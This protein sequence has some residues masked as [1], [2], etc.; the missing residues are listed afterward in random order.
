M[1]EFP[2]PK[3]RSVFFDNKKLYACLAFH[4][5]VEGHTIVVWK[6]DVEDLNDLSFSNY[7]YFMETVYRTRKALLSFFKTDKVYLAYLDE[8]RHVHMHL[9]PRKKDSQIKGFQLMIQPQK[10]IADLM[11]KARLLDTIYSLHKLMMKE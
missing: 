9:L 2:D 5:V 11:N 3:E 8:A 4:P 6:T 10:E 7:Q 1:A